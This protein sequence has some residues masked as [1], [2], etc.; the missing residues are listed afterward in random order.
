MRSARGRAGA[1]VEALFLADVSRV[2]NELVVVDLGSDD[3]APMEGIEER[4][5]GTDVTYPI[6]RRRSPLAP[7]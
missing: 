5:I 4:S 3:E 2:A 7:R 6:F 1:T